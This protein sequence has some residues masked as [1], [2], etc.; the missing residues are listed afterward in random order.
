MRAP[1]GGLRQGL[2][3]R[4]RQYEAR[5]QANTV[6]LDEGFEPYPDQWAFLA[7][8]VRMA[9]ATVAAIAREAERRGQIV[10]MGFAAPSD[11]DED[12]PWMRLPSER[13]R[14]E[15]VS[16]PLPKEVRAVVA[17]RLFVDKAGLP[18]PLLNAI[19]RLAA[20]QNPEFYKKQSLRLSTAMT[21]RVIACAEEFS[22]YIS[23]P[24]GCRAD[25]QHDI[26]VLVAPPGIGKTVLGTYL[27]AERGRSTLVLVHRR[28]LLDQWRC[29][30][31]CRS[32]GRG[33]WYNMLGA[34]TG[35]T[36]GRRRFATSAKTC[37]ALWREE[38][39]RRPGRPEPAGGH[40]RRGD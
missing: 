18:S 22:Q 21:P 11:E 40:Q 7:S 35:S 32:R 23:L 16:G 9:P 14:R 13:P 29:S 1:R 28:P 3:E 8:V 27:I 19:K 36:R 6:F 30:W 37:E 39:R 26:G 20:F 25:L 34:C 31:R 10:G 15:P 24:R 2:M 33:R 5:Q 17:Q 4:R 38:A 12:A